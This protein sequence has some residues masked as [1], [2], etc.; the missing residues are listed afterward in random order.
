MKADVIMN[1]TIKIVLVPETDLERVALEEFSKSA[2]D[3]VLIDK[4]TQILD[5]VIHNGII[6]KNVSK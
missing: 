2:C 5:K 3:T 1:G 6:V 4:Q